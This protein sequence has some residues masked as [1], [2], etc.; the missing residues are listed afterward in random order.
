MNHLQM[1]TNAVASQILRFEL[2]HIETVGLMFSVCAQI[3]DCHAGCCLFLL[4][5]SDHSENNR[6][7]Y[8]NG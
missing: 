1:S 3:V 5:D 6:A 2:K 4:V 7:M 8:D